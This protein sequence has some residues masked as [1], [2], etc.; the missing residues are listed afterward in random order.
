MEAGQGVEG[1]V[2]LTLPFCYV[3]DMPPMTEREIDLFC[4][5]PGQVCIVVRRSD[6]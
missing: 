2:D 4:E 3:H 5:D 6:V 1:S